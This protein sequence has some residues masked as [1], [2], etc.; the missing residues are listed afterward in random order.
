MGILD[1][2][3]GGSKETSTTIPTWIED[4]MKEA[5]GRSQAASRIG[6]T[7]YYGADVAAFTP[8]QEASFANTNRMAGLLGMQGG[9]AP[10]MPQAKNFGGVMGYSSGDLYDQAV[11]ELAQRRPGQKAAIDAQFID[12]VTGARSQY[13][14]DIIANALIQG[15][16]DPVVAKSVAGGNY[17]PQSESATGVPLTMRDTLQSLAEMPGIAQAL[18]PGAGILSA[19]SRAYVNNQATDTTNNYLDTNRGFSNDGTTYRSSY[20]TTT[21]TSSISDAAKRGLAISLADQKNYNEGL[22]N[23]NSD[24][25]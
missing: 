1:T 8:S 5:I 9:S 19:L 15:G 21:P 23:V 17:D 24:F 18:I 10:S 3:F 20:G 13:D 4:A 12:P 16:V 22:F 14:Q 11:N 6:Y 2:I 25:M 7:P